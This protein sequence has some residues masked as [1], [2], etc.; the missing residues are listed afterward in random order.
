[1]E[2][3]ANGVVNLDNEIPIGAELRSAAKA[4]VRQDRLVWRGEWKVEEEGGFGF[5]STLFKKCDRL[6]FEMVQAVT[7]DKVR[8]ARSTPEK[9]GELHR[10]L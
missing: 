6:L 10:R 5:A 2:H 1:M 9:T 7:H 8:A 4:G 3:G